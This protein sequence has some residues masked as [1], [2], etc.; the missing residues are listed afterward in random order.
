MRAL[1]AR[2]PHTTPA[3]GGIAWTRASVAPRGRRGRLQDVGLDAV[4]VEQVG[5]LHGR[6]S[7]SPTVL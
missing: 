5:K 6:L 1:A 2:S 3:R 4:P 7:V